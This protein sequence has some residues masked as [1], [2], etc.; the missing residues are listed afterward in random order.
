M[1]D[2]FLQ[3]DAQDLRAAVA[4]DLM[5]HARALEHAD[6][7]VLAVAALQQHLD[8]EIDGKADGDRGRI[9]PDDDRI[10]ACAGGLA[11][12]RAHLKAA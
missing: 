10:R 2:R 7:H 1:A 8:H 5:A 3:A 9:E 12:R 11:G 4:A 6:F